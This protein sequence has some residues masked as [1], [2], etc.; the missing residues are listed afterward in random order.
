M[1]GAVRRL[2]PVASCAHRCGS[3][4]AEQRALVSARAGVGHACRVARSAVLLSLLHGMMV[5][6][7]CLRGRGAPS[8]S[9]YCK[10]NPD[11]NFAICH[12]P[13][14]LTDAE[15]DAETAQV[16]ARVDVGLHARA[17]AAAACMHA[18]AVSA[19]AHAVPA[20]CQLC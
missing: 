9:R 8:A 6:S 4:G 17:E 2:S 16:R 11:P 13:Q 18:P 20:V 19:G 7:R 10:F 3:N 12:T 15:I 5:V 1:L 14:E